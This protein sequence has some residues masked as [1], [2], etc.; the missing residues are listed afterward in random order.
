[1]LASTQVD[2]LPPSNGQYE[3]EHFLDFCRSLGVN[4]SSFCF[5]EVSDNNVLS[6][7]CKMNS[8]KA[9]GLDLLSP[10]FIKDGS[11]LIA[12]PLTYIL[13]LSLSTGEIQVNLKSGKVMPIYKKNSK[14]EAGNYR[15]ISILNTI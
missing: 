9:T 10:R 7:L 13:N 14:M 2:Q 15:P 8:S 6:I 4:S 1:M 3:S 12:Y 11:K 5:S